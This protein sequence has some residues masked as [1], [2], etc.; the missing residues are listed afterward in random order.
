MSEYAQRISAVPR[1]Q[2][3][4]EVSGGI[5]NRKC[6]GHVRKDQGAKKQKK[7]DQRDDSERRS[8]KI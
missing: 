5:K 8:A 3:D 6:S 7:E 1:V 4:S 2:D